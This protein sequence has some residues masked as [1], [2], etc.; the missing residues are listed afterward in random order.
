MSIEATLTA[1]E[2]KLLLNL[3]SRTEL[4]ELVKLTGLSEVEAMRAVQWL[5]NKG[6]VKYC[7]KLIE[8]VLLGKNGKQY[9][10][11]GLPERRFLKAL[12]DG[13]TKLT[14][15]PLSKDELQ[16]SIGLLKRLNAIEI[17]STKPLSFKLT[18]QGMSLL[19]R[20]TL[21]ESFLETLSKP[22]PVAELKPE[23]KA[24]LNK[25]LSRKAIVEIK[26]KKLVFVEPTAKANNLTELKDEELIGRL[27]K[28]IIVS[29]DWKKRKFRTYDLIAPVPKLRGGRRHVLSQVIEY[30]RRI[31]LDMGFTEMTGRL[32]Q[33]GFWNFDAL[34]TAQDHPVR[35]IH[36][37]FF[38]KHPAKGKLP[39]KELV[40]RVQR[41]HENGWTTGSKGW[42]YR[43]DSEEAKLNVMRTH[44][45]SLSARTLAALKPDEIPGKYFA[46]GRNFRNETIDWSHSFEFYQVEGIVV[47]KDVSFRHLLGYLRAYYKKLGYDKVRF[48]PAYFPYTEPSVE[49]EV[50]LADKRKWIELGGAG[51]FRPEVVKPLLGLD[52]PVLAWGQGLERGIMEHLG[53]NDLRKI[54]TCDTS[55]INDQRVWLRCQ[56]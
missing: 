53:V 17:N 55:E 48:R 40:E 14:E 49:A 3:K 47:A 24:A 6:L 46:V 54:Y 5:S 36:D 13:K 25:L 19:K 8:E 29:G 27:T 1:P 26:E 56:Q 31:W 9:I 50:Y 28:Q 15:I 30:I 43:W 45:T 11:K 51:I 7:T 52:I 41:T 16:V 33:T 37:T 44:T 34:F 23:E 42:N 21:E 10:K 38:I 22:R 4:S 20:K 39:S 12:S 35:D 2:R 18:E 32:V